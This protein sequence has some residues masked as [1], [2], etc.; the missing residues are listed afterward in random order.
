MGETSTVEAV[1]LWRLRRHRWSHSGATGKKGVEAV[2]MSPP[3]PGGPLRM[4]LA[5]GTYWFGLTGACPNQTLI[6]RF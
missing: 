1:R 6:L 4:P 3:A 2:V 5:E